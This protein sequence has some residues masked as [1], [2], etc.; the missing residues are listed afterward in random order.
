M[1][2]HR[3]AWRRALAL[4]VAA[5]LGLVPALASPPA[6]AAEPPTLKIAITADFESFNPFTTVYAA[7]INI[8]RLQFESLVEIGP[9]NELV[10]GMAEKWETSPDGTV[11]TF[12]LPSGRTWSDG[13][14]L[15]AEDP[16]WT[17]EQVRT[18]AK[19][20]AANA[21]LLENVEAVTAKDPSTLV[22][23]MKRPQAAN[24]GS[25]LPVVPKHVW[26]KLSDK[27]TYMTQ[28]TEPV[29]GSGPY[30]IVKY[31][32]G[33]SV[34]LKANPRFWRGAPKLGGITYVYYKNTDAAVQGLRSGEVDLVTG[35]TAAQ[36]GALKDQ[37]SIKVSNGKGRRYQAVAINPG[38][39]TVDGQPL[40]D[41]NPVLKDPQVR[42]AIF[43][44]IDSTTLIERV[45]GGLAKPGVTQVPPVYPDYYGL[46]EGAV[47]RTFD[48]A[49]ANTIL[50]DA[51]YPKGA[52]GVRQD[53][54]GKPIRL[55]LLG[56]TTAAEHAQMADFIKQWLRQIGIEVE[57]TMASNSQVGNDSTLGKYDLYFT[58][59]G[60]GPDPD[61]QLSI[62]QCSSRPNADGSGATSEN[63]WCDPAFDALYEAQRA[64]L[65]PA[66]RAQLV[67]KAYQMIY[68]AN[69]LDVLY[70]AD[71]LEAWRTDKVVDFPR[72]PSDGGVIY[73]QSSYWSLYG[74]EPVTQ[75]GAQGGSGTGL[76]VG[77]VTVVVVLGGLGFF[78]ARRRSASADSRE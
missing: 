42:R 77:V 61:Y 64:E 33:Q 73:G 12:T 3:S 18:D 66:K 30:Q 75:S 20:G 48:I 63:N 9:D 67:K 78:W 53:K 24:P 29:V 14:P 68:D 55:R 16:A 10:G 8:N 51:G 52:D 62:N 76:V 21:S 71:V 54:T 22:V 15:T 40:G 13:Q 56:R 11:W 39:L 74:A 65:D 1:P 41:G 34:E 72:Q 2:H 19:L 28:I 4:T 38:A 37:P 58:G 47:Q 69:V 70:Y 27:T 45:L 32:K 59:W 36:Y 17:F 31:A 50:D 43:S 26:E 46:P 35:L 57:V 7:P 5:A 6:R 25:E 44:A 23:T 60:I 49:A